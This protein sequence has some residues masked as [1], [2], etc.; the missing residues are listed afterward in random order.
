MGKDLSKLHTA[1]MTFHMANN[2][3]AMLQAY[4][5]QK[6]IETMGADCEILDYRLQCIYKRDGIYRWKEMIQ[7]SGFLKGNARYVWRHLNGR[8]RNLT[9]LQ[10]K[11]DRFMRNDLKLSKKT[12]FQKDKLS[13]TGYDA[14]IFG[15][16]QIWNPSRTGGFAPEYLGDYFDEK[17]TALIAYAASCGM[18]HLPEGYEDQF[19][20]R[21][22]KFTGI[23]VRE[24]SLAKNLREECGIPAE[25]VLDPVLL[26]D[27]SIWEP[28]ARQAE[29]RIN[30]PYLLIYTFDAGDDIYKVA[31]RTA[32][33]RNLKPVA[34]CYK[35][36]PH[37]EGIEQILTAGPKDFLA[38]MKNADFVC[39]TS[40]HGLAFSILLEKN[41]YCMAHPEV[42]QRERDLI[43]LSGLHDRFLEHFEDLKD[44]TD[45]DYREAGKRI[46]DHRAQSYQFLKTA[47]EASVR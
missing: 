19:L 32:K 26:A 1:V 29:I 31:L 38:L 16:D 33:E 8:Y 23:S 6:T 15:S 2:Y 34:L 47:L 4:A 42:G 35:K 7:D 24:K 43:D 10:K 12:Y 44:I 37:L 22:K 30:E 5:L 40:F 25:A 11:F 27:P 13:K 36:N 17:K 45:C 39:T 18:D 20:E 9:P 21:L 14:V 41:F 28:L 3:G 46:A